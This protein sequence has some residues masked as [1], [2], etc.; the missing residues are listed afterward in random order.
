[1]PAGV[2]RRRE[3]PP[4]VRARR[5]ARI[6]LIAVPRPRLGTRLQLLLLFALLLATGVGLL[7]LD[8]Y[9][10][11]RTQQAQN[12][13]KDEALQG[14]RRIMAV[15]EAYG[16]DIVD[17]VN[18]RRY[19]QISWPQAR[20]A[21]AAAVMRIDLHWA[22][23]LNLPRSEQQQG[24][25]EQ[26][27]QARAEADRGIEQLRT[28]LQDED[29]AALAQFADSRLYPLI[30]PVTTRLRYLS[31]LLMIHA[32]QV[33]RD[34]VARSD[35]IGLLRILLSLGSLSVVA[36]AGWALARNI[37]QG[38]GSLL[39]LSHQMRQ[40]NFDVE[41][42]HRPGG[43]LGEVIDAF[44]LM[45]TEVR[46]YAHE[47]QV[48]LESNDEVRRWLQERDIFQRSL[49]SAAQTAILSIDTDGH[50]THV[51]PF[52]ERL[53]GYRADQL[54][55]IASPDRL[56]DR[57]QLAEVARELGV[58]GLGS[59]AGWRLFL[60]LA[61]QQQPAR[62][63]SLI[64]AD[65]SRLAALI[66]VS[67][68]ASSSGELRGLLFVATDLT[69]IK[70]LEHELRASEQR[71]REAS[72]AKSAFLAAMSHEIRT[73]MIGVTGMV[74]VL[75]H[76]RLDPDQ[77]R[78]LA[79]I[80][81]S[82]D[83]LLQII[84]DIL[85]FSKIEAGR[86]DL[87]PLTV[88]L[89][90]LLAASVYNF[91]GA[92][93]SKGLQL[94]YEIDP[95]LGEAHRVD[96]VRLRQI[97]GNFLSNAIKFTARGSITVRLHALGRAAGS[98]QL[99]F[100]VADT[101][102]GVSEAARQ[103]LF[104]P[105]AQAEADTTRR[106]GGTGLGL[107]ICRRLAE[108]MG[109][110]VEMQSEPGAGTTMRLQLALP[111]ASAEQ[112]E[113]GADPEPARRPF[114]PRPLPS[115]AEAEAERS[116]VLLVD[117]HPTNRQVIVRQLAL[118]GFV[119]ETA[120]D[121]RDG[122]QRWISGRYA[123]VLSDIHM[124]EMDGYQMTR[125]IRAI[126]A[127]DGRP[128]TPILALTAAAMKG[129]AERCL[130]AGMDD[131]MSKPVTVALLLERLRRWL[132]HLPAAGYRPAAAALPQTDQPP[133]IDPAVLL[134]VCGA[135]LAAQRELLQDFLASTGVDLDRLQQ[136]Q[137]DAGPVEI[138]RQAHRIKGA[139]R[140]VGALELAA[141]AE[142]LECAASAEDLAGLH[143]LQAELPTVF[144]RLRLYLEQRDGW[145]A[146][147]SELGV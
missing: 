68:M 1:L 60:T 58:T 112:I 48:T 15:S 55:G 76:T 102:I 146:A 99:E 104:Q 24:L 127:R 129:E 124:P 20:G 62:E 26:I 21:V 142:A 95:G 110:Q 71:A 51:N 117:D 27:G 133:P 114:A 132:P 85:D 44:L 31:D 81:H 59:A 4:P 123:L 19:G 28:I 13:L 61:E 29:D 90:R 72:Q 141:A 113:A 30:E 136:L 67:S 41:P 12:E 5:R 8:E 79:V 126:E 122:L 17:A 80:Q 145:L 82:A 25:F 93:S 54:I 65:G 10:R 130:A 40:R 49:L 107:A 16:G 63:W 138:G 11:H 97:L 86:M 34:D 83:N 103:R 47:L 115:L 118:A 6:G 52:A 45:R 106:Y 78:I 119:C 128:H 46:R 75:G 3:R 143:A 120:E 14:L 66:G 96:P 56:H 9:S 121:G 111:L 84:G 70:Q 125:A 137:R 94:G 69:A 35:R 23:L 18:K 91:T 147:G 100:S 98:E 109:G 36:L 42:R 116:L 32:E 2:A 105:F 50:Y 57:E 39:Q 74:E 33:V 22:A 89:R 139:A 37:H 77:Q 134:D 7:L 101:G 135:D 131:Y 144:E 43:E 73:P 64:R 108:L 38:L 88:D 140:L 92:A 53:L 87:A